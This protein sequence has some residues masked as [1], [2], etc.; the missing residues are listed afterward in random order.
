[1][2]RSVKRIGLAA[3]LSVAALSSATAEEELC[4][5]RFSSVVD[6]FKTIST[7]GLQQ[8]Q[9]PDNQFVA[10]VDPENHRLWNFTTPYHPAHPS[11]ACREVMQEKTGISIATNLV[12]GGQKADCERLKADYDALSEKMKQGPASLAPAR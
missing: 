7:S 4:G 2:K 9:T 6:L 5:K 11:V 1:M 12:C 10:Y 3:L 8:E